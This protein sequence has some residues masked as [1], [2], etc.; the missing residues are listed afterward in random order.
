MCLREYFVL[1]CAPTDPYH[2]SNKSINEVIDLR[3]VLYNIII[4]LQVLY[5]KYVQLLL[6]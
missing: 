2:K 4:I 6:T 1:L 3:I 5:Y